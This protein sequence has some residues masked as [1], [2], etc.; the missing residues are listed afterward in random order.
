[1]R[2]LSVT[3]RNYR[4]HKECTVQFDPK[5]TLISGEN[6]SG[7][8][9]LAEA[10]HRALFF[11][12]KAG[13]EIRERMTSIW[14][15]PPQVLLCF[16]VAGRTVRLEK[17]FHPS[18]GECRLD[19][20]GE[21]K[22]VGDAAEERLAALLKSGGP[23]GGQGAETH[24]G[25]R[26]AH[27]WVWQGQSNVQPMES[28]A[29]Q[30]DN[31]MRR[32]RQEGGMALAQ[33][34]FDARILRIIRERRDALYTEQGKVRVGTDLAAAER[35]LA[36]ARERLKERE[37]VVAGVEEAIRKHAQASQVIAEKQAA[38][39]PHRAMLEQAREVLREA[40]EI[41]RA[42]EPLVRTVTER[43]VG[44]AEL[45]RIG[46]LIAVARVESREASAAREPHRVALNA[47]RQEQDESR[48]GMQALEQAWGEARAGAVVERQWLAALSARLQ[49]IEQGLKRDS[50]EADRRRIEQVRAE[51]AEVG[52][53]MAR[54]PRVSRQDVEALDKL[55]SRR[56]AA[57]AA[58]E[59]MG[60]RIEVV[61]SREPVTVDGVALAPGAGMS[62]T[63]DVDVLIGSVA[64][65]RVCS[66]GAAGIVEARQKVALAE[67]ALSERL[68]ALGVAR[69]EE[70]VHALELL[71]GVQS[72]AGVLDQELARLDPEG[73]ETALLECVAACEDAQRRVEQA[74]RECGRALPEGRDAV[75]ESFR[76]AE[77][78]CRGADR[79][80]KA[81]EAALAAARRRFT[82]AEAALAEAVRADGEAERLA[83]DAAV[84]VATLEEQHG[85]DASRAERR[86]DWMAE[87][88]LAVEK[89]AALE[90]RL[91]ELR[92]E[93]CEADIR[94]LEAAIRQMEA[95]VQDAVEVR[96][97]AAAL[98]M[99]SGHQDPHDELAR[100]VADV[101]RAEA[102]VGELRA[103]A[104]AIRYLAQVAEEAGKAE[105]DR[106]RQQLAGVV[107]G[108]LACLYGVGA[109]VAFE[110]GLGDADGRSVRVMR[111]AASLGAFDFGA[112]SC[113]AREQVAMA[114]RLGMA[115]VLAK[116][117][118]GCLPVV[119]DDVFVNSDATRVAGLQRMLYH[120]AAQ[121]LQVIVLTCSP[122]DYAGLG[123]REIALERPVG[124]GRGV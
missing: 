81:A 12:A 72:R 51:Q 114:L 88:D 45:E 108:Y 76:A 71:R 85:T 13:G 80:E 7:K 47:R 20:E 102:R 22:L 101:E 83:Q 95:G 50:L 26:W 84:R 9:T 38:L 18:R 123:A 28:I 119:L 62:V 70:A 31:L 43:T 106:I 69:R 86:K 56:V 82:A 33:S 115:Q 110:G 89:R 98:L 29:E 24:L 3:V 75:R 124:R 37:R 60:S 94:R 5:L 116:D 67:Q 121:G 112:L 57:E 27:L 39:G 109:A 61:E 79:D 36:V 8:S 68:R 6:E 46:K 49:A 23:I 87:R 41:R 99:Q 21:S 73:N 19:V 59:A 44:I 35:N 4:V 54:T 100:A 122:G 25:R 53:Q 40:A 34:D 111:E 117:H 55:E 10:V 15:E 105:S 92:A 91:V 11:R 63:R 65:L 103:Q 118:D 96:A 66:G 64:R 2:I 30:R 48:A 104:E 32:L 42:I 77:A 1:M 74:A 90:G 14:G 120:A 107:G 78:V 58:L 17:T 97:G 113:G 93:Q 16:E 52:R